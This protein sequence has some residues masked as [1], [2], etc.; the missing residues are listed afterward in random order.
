MPKPL[1][2]YSMLKRGFTVVELVITITVMGILLTLAVINISST[3]VDARDSERKSDVESIANHLE[4]FY[5]SGTTG[6]TVFGRYPSTQLLATG[7]TSV[8]T[9]L[10][11]IDLSNVT[12]PGATSVVSSFKAAT[13]NTQTEVGVVPN[14]TISQYVYQPIQKDGVL[15]TLETQECRKYVLYY[16][17]EVDNTVKKIMSK[18]Q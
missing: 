12:A 5:K 8:K 14:P 4:I 17:S 11:D 10:P 15:C 9:F 1:M 7:E 6:S 13:N 3:Q 18:N 16:R 2:L